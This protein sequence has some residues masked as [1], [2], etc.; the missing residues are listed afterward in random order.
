[1]VRKRTV[2]RPLELGKEELEDRLRQFE[3]F[4]YNYRKYRQEYGSCDT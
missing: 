3:Q 2:V 4:L 1:L